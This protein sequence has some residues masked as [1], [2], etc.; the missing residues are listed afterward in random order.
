[1]KP[2]L[3]GSLFFPAGLASLLW[4]D[5]ADLSAVNADAP[6]DALALSFSIVDFPLAWVFQWHAVSLT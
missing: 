6:G 2:F 5:N 3:C 4:W 1:L